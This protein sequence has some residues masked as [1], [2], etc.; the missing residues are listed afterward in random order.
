MAD[1]PKTESL[2]WKNLT[3][4]GVVGDPVRHSL[5]PVIHNEWCRRA[6]VNGLYLPLKIIDDDKEFIRIIDGLKKAGFT[7]LNVTMPHKARALAYAHNADRLATAIDAANM[8]TLTGLKIHG[9]T[10]DGYGFSQALKTALKIPGMDGSCVDMGTLKSALVMGAGGATGAVCAALCDLGVAHI[11]I[12]NRTHHKGVALAATLKKL[13]PQQQISVVAWDDR[14]TVHADL[15]INTTSLGMVDMPPLAFTIS[16]DYGHRVIADI[17]YKPLETAL[18]KQAREQNLVS[19]NGLDMLM[20]QAVPGFETW[21]GA[22]AQ[23]DDDLR[24]LLLDHIAGTRKKPFQTI[25]L[26]GSIGMGKSTVAKMIADSGV[27]IWDADAGVHR[28]YAKGGA[29]VSALRADFPDAIIDGTV[30]RTVLGKLVLNDPG[31]MAILESIIH[32]LVAIDRQLFLHKVAGSGA[33][34]C[35][36]DIPLL[37]EGGMQDDYDHVVVVSADASVQRARVL[38]RRGMTVEKFEAILARQMPDDE[39]R[40]RASHII[41]TDTSLDETRAAVR[42]LMAKLQLHA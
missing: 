33:P 9:Q 10:S 37:F 31:K 22:A 6:K 21:F 20:Y 12:T 4:A 18:L 24:R 7:G 36:L 5:S 28:L 13:A 25:A 3:Y 32:P 1:I 14:Q 40:K 41:A 16:P 34:L 23:V 11:T 17:V 8:L 30:D 2:T 19:V 39:K 26:T 27:P 29:A 42:D 35:L 15:V 38:A